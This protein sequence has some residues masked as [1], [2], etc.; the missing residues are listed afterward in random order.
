MLPNP[1]K[2]MPIDEPSRLFTAANMLADGFLDNRSAGGEI[3]FAT[4]RAEGLLPIKVGGLILIAYEEGLPPH[5]CQPRRHLVT[6][7]EAA[8]Y[9]MQRIDAIPVPEPV[10]GE[11][12]WNGNP[13]A[14]LK[15]IVTAQFSEL[16]PTR[17]HRRFPY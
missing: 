5:E 10:K 2:T 6:R 11:I 9:G 15:S 12:R 13:L 7:T 1:C 8:E 3:R 4:P 17:R 14:K 16:P